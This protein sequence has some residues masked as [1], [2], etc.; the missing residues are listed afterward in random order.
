MRRGFVGIDRF[1]AI[2]IPA[3]VDQSRVIDFLTE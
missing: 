2:L 1:F 3:T